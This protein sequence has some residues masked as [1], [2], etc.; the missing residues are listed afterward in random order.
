MCTPYSGTSTGLVLIIVLLSTTAVLQFWDPDRNGRHAP[1]PLVLAH[2]ERITIAV[3]L[4]ESSNCCRGLDCHVGAIS[5]LIEKFMLFSGFAICGPQPF[6]LS[7]SD[8]FSTCLDERVSSS[9]DTAKQTLPLALMAF[10]SQV[11]MARHFVLRFTRLLASPSPRLATSKLSLY[12][13]VDEK[14]S[15]EN[16]RLVAHRRNSP[17]SVMPCDMA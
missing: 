9:Q 7:R 14:E 2:I 3:A 12:T 16:K 17:A 10:Q 1:A 13:T 8:R 11:T 5:S 15:G 4:T 6:V